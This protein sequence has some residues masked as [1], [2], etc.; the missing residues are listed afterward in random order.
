MR[1]MIILYYYFHTYFR[2]EEKEILKKIESDKCDNIEKNKNREND[3]RKRKCMFIS[4]F[5]KIRKHLI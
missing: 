1:I 2:L 5:K 3:E 4:F